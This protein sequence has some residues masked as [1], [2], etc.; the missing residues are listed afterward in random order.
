[1]PQN[2]ESDQGLHCLQTVWPFFCKNTYISKLDVSKIEIRI[3][4]Y[5]VSGGSI[6]STVG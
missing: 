5:I 3:F 6:Q 1:M 2:A 4:Q